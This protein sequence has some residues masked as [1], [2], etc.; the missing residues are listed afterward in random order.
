M[1]IYVASSWR[2]KKVGDVVSALR[3]HGHEVYDFREDDEDGAAFNWS[4]IDPEWQKWT[5]DEFVKNLGHPRA[6]AGFKRDFE[7][8]KTCDAVVLV[9]PCGRS[10]HLELG[11]AVGAGKRT[12]ILLT[13]GEPE[14][15]YRMVDCLSAHITF[16]LT[17]LEGLESADGRLFRTEALPVTKMR[18]E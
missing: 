5:P 1:K 13:D 10:A 7:A 6:D 16:I 3:R 4:D 12:A 11:Y 14:L 8:L 17:W 18:P 15:C 9:M 2:N